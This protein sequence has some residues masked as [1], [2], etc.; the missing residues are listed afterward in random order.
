MYKKNVMERTNYNRYVFKALEAYPYELAETMEALNYA[1]S[2]DTDNVK[3]LCLMGKVYA[4]Q[5]GDYEMAKSYFEQALENGLEMPYIYPDYIATLI[6]NE[7]LI[8]AQKVLEYARKVKGSNKAV[9]Y[10][11]QSWL[12]EQWRQYKMAIKAMEQVKVH[13]YNADYQDYAEREIVRIKKKLPK[14]GKKGKN[15]P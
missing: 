2:Y 5:L 9:L 15:R 4:E 7:D 14:K 10:N 6:L 12:F 1:L 3:A 8:E 11:L 13:A